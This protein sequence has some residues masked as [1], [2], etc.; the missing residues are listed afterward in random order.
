MQA[1]SLRKIIMSIAS[2]AYKKNS[3]ESSVSVSSPI[4]L[5]ILVYERIL[6]HLR[7][8]KKECELGLYGVEYF[9]SACNLINLGLLAPL[10]YKEGKEIAY[11]LKNIYTWCLKEIMSARLEKSSEKIQ[12][13]IDVLTPLYEGWLAIAPQK[14]LRVLTSMSMVKEKNYENQIYKQI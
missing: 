5:V 9:D 14:Q 1:N 3:I 8:G 12:R 10:D 6:E 11:D 7:L 2:K 13:V 4:E